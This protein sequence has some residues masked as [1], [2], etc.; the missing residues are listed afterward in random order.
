MERR[1]GQNG[2]LFSSLFLRRFIAVYIDLLILVLPCGVVALAVRLFFGKTDMNS[3]L[4]LSLPL[5]VLCPLCFFLRDLL[6]PSPG[7]R[8]MG[9]RLVNADGT[10]NVPAKRLIF[11]HLTWGLWPVELYFL[12]KSGGE[13]RWGDRLMEIK[14]IR[15]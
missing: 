1:L 14:L 4:T 5:I 3:A 10:E 15:D 7:K 11:R 12:I 13:T 8:L 2:G 9:L 6:R